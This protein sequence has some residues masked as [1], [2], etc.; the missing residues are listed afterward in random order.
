MN[1][2]KSEDREVFGFQ[3]ISAENNHRIS[4]SIGGSGFSELVVSFKSGKT[5]DNGGEPLA[6]RRR[7]TAFVMFRMEID[8][9]FRVRRPAET[10]NAFQEK[11]GVVFAALLSRA[12]RSGRNEGVKA[13]GW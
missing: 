4:V 10:R 8:I 1:V 12:E 6:G 2:L 5:G 9:D 3:R 11:P 13:T 7:D